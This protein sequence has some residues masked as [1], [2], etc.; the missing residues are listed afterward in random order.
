MTK[1]LASKGFTLLEL[2]LVIGISAFIALIAWSMIDLLIRTRQS[3]DQKSEQIQSLQAS[4]SQWKSDLNRMVNMPGVSSWSWDGRTLRITRQS[5]AQDS[6]LVVVA[7]RLVT[8][9]ETP[10]TN[11]LERWQSKTTSTNAQWMAAWQVASQAS[12]STDRGLQDKRHTIP[13][14]GLMDWQLWNYSNGEWAQVMA[15]E[16][17]KKRLQDGEAELPDG[18]RLVLQHHA[19]SFLSGV[20]F[21]DWVNP[22]APGRSP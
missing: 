7:W 10:D 5:P 20:V 18:F 15:R 3:A 17:G 1:K 22:T 21:L 19:S 14:R 2:L 12:D 8:D 11:M 4:F 13:M 16:V 6:G 9:N